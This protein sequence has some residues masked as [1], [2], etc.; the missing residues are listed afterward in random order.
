MD[1]HTAMLNYARTSRA[2][3]LA[4]AFCFVLAGALLLVSLSTP[5]SPRTDIGATPVL[6]TT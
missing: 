3:A 1:L 5:R 4:A 6:Q 2:T